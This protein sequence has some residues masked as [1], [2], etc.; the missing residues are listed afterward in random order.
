MQD[1]VVI[2][3]QVENLP[4][5]VHGEAESKNTLQAA[6]QQEVA[7]HP[8]SRQSGGLF[9]R[10]GRWIAGM[11]V[12][13]VP[14]D[15]ALCAFDCQKTQCTT[16]EWAHCERRLSRAAG[17]LWPQNGAAEIEPGCGRKDDN[18]SAVH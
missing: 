13:D 5:E 16:E 15:S 18:S 7:S 1:R 10:F 9:R 8:S 14:D 12:Q 4:D 11:V 17:E 3:E 2:L 6:P